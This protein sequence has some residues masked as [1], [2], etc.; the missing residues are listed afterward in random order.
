MKREFISDNVKKERRDMGQWEHLVGLWEDDRIFYAFDCDCFMSDIDND[1]NEEK[2]QG[3]ENEGMGF[4][5]LV[6]G[7][8]GELNVNREKN[9]LIK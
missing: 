7:N 8:A 9:E 3:D 5:L 2:K 4:P 1:S 6:L